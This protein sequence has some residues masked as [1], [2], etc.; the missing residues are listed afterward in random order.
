MVDVPAYWFKRVSVDRGCKDKL[1][2]IEDATQAKEE[3]DYSNG[4]EKVSLEDEVPKPNPQHGEQEPFIKALKAFGGNSV[5]NV[6]LFHGKM[7]VE[8]VLE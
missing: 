2:E 7:D 5:E 1:K 4:K 6:S 8:V 3:R